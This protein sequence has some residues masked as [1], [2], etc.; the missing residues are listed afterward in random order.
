MRKIIIRIIVVI[1]LFSTNIFLINKF[2][3][4]I[5][6]IYSFLIAVILITYLFLLFKKQNNYKKKYCEMTESLKKLY[7]YTDKLLNLF[8]IYFD[9][10]FLII[11]SVFKDNK[12]LENAKNDFIVLHEKFKDYKKQ[13]VSDKHQDKEETI[14][15]TNSLM[16]E[17]DTF[18]EI[19]ESIENNLFIEIKDKIDISIK[20]ENFQQM[21]VEYEYYSEMLYEFIN[22][23][24]NNTNSTLKPLSEEIL[25]IK[26]CV[27]IFIN[28]I[29]AWKD[30]LSAEKSGKSFGTLISQYNKQSEDFNN[31]TL[32][33]NNNYS[34]LEKNLINIVNM[35][36]T[37]FENS[38]Q[39]QGIA[40]KIQI[41]SINASI[42]SSKAGEYGKGFRIIAN[43]IKKM[44]SDTQAFT[45]NILNEINNTKNLAAKAM[46]EFEKQ[47]MEINK[48]I[49]LQKS[50]FEVFYI[51]LTNY[52]EDFNKVFSLV[53]DL[54]KD[55]NVHI[56]KFNPIFQLHDSSVQELENLNKMI[57]RFLQDNKE[58]M[59]KIIQA[60]DEDKKNKI[61]NKL[62]FNIEERI[63]TDMEIVV[64]NKIS[65]KYNLNRNIKINNIN[66]EMF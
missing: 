1:I 46:E 18:L 55:I 22:S 12:E 57:T 29:T 65:E 6:S 4:I 5:S 10:S 45:N 61:L 50:G 44:S 26:Q 58:E 7:E 43:E 64:V 13:A 9:N 36:E 8:C 62:L 24:I 17:V 16:L 41:L 23:I 32:N 42:E 3:P 34:N 30:D 14:N 60:T 48:K 63:T 19:L 37:V 47:G 59:S 66:I 51:M 28:N 52:Y 25:I 54:T 56:D 21:V 33:I 2:D 35:V 15:K 53:S 31:V 27:N 11:H 49:D 40:E 38:H 20:K 39:I